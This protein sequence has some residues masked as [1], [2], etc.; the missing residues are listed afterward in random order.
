MAEESREIRNMR[1]MAW[2]RA[3]GELRSIKQ[4][5][6]NNDN[7]VPYCRILEQF[8]RDVENEGIIE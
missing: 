2:E 1:T 3:K 5:Y 4:T 8:I 7:Y 6:W